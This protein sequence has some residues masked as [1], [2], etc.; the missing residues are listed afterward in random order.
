[1]HIYKIR[2]FKKLETFVRKIIFLSFLDFEF[3]VL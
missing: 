1:M 3:P 2:L